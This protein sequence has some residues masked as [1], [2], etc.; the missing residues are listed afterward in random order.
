MSDDRAAPTSTDTGTSSLASSLY[1]HLARGEDGSL[2][3]AGVDTA[4]RVQMEGIARPADTSLFGDRTTNGQARPTA[5]SGP[6]PAAAFNPNNYAAPEG[7]PIEPGLLAEFT[8]QAKSLG[9]GHEG[10]SKLLD[11]HHKAMRA[12]LDHYA[13]RLANDAG[14]LE[15]TLPAHDLAAAREL[16][17]DDQ[18]TPPELRPWLATWGNHP[19]VAQLLTRWASAIRNGRRY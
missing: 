1:P 4:R 9:I 3:E 14:Q 15:R 11:L 12:E 10:G 7:G 16:I 5:P 6:T 17:N 13:Q 19:L 8:N 18:M 2:G